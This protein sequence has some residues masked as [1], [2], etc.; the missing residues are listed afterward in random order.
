MHLKKNVAFL[1]TLVRP[2]SLP[3]LEGHLL[4][5][6][7]GSVCWLSLGGYL[8][9]ASFGTVQTN[10]AYNVYDVFVHAVRHLTVT[11]GCSQRASTKHHAWQ[12]ETAQ[13]AHKCVDFLQEGLQEQVAKTGTTIPS[14]SGMKAPSDKQGFPDIAVKSHVA[15]KTWFQRTENVLPEALCH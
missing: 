9:F 11:Q 7:F 4:F 5:T 15:E 13:L 3:T 14:R 2:A 8:W 6:T 1:K 12:L 10:I